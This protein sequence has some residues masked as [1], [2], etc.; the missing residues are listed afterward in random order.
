MTAPE[1]AGPYP[2]IVLIHSFNGLEPGYLTLADRFAARD[3]V[4]IA[5]QGDI[6][7]IAIR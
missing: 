1:E 2:G 4:V 5:P 7:Q 3:Y 6:Q